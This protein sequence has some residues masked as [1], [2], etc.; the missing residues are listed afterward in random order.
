MKELLDGRLA[1]ITNSWG[2]L[3]APLEKVAEV[4]SKWRDEHR[5]GME[6]MSL[7]GSLK[8]MLRRLEPLS[9]PWMNELWVRTKSDWTAYFQGTSRVADPQSPIGHLALILKCQGLAVSCV[10]HTLTARGRNAKGQYGSVQF[11][12]F[13]GEKIPGGFINYRRSVSAMND[14]GKWT[15]STGGEPLD[16]EK[17]ER[18]AA[19]R[20]I[21]RFTVEH[22]EEYC[23]ALGIRVL[24]PDFYGPDGILFRLPDALIAQCQFKSIEEA[25][26]EF[27]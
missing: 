17:P 15:F 7:V 11:I 14:G 20:V 19:K 18:Y 21:E 12:L 22:L 4:F 23:E 2:F 10:P 5:P 26:R 25:Q 13:A 16:F 9:M 6:Q 8:E 27:Q 3:Q 24:D 1:P